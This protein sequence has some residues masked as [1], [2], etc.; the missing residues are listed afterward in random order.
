MFAIIWQCF[1]FWDPFG[2][3]FEG[4]VIFLDVWDASW[5]ERRCGRMRT[6][7]CQ[8]VHDS[9]RFWCFC[10]VHPG[11]SLA[12]LSAH[13]SGRP[14]KVHIVGTLL[15][16]GCDHDIMV[17]SHPLGGGSARPALQNMFFGHGHL[18]TNSIGPFSFSLCQDG[19]MFMIA[20]WPI[21]SGRL[22]QAEEL[23][24]RALK[25]YKA[26]SSTTLMGGFS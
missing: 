1:R 15:T 2:G 6:V 8:K 13:L 10:F 12:F 11:F 21:T 4:V 24:L 14:V 5:H 17:V 9:W 7:G 18:P 23:Y 26:G 22:V 3:V 25:G 16:H 19:K 20:S